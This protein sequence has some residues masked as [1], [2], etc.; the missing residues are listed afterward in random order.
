MREKDKEG[1]MGEEK[2]KKLCRRESTR[3]EDRRKERK[4]V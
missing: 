2:S 4:G 3:H 1:K